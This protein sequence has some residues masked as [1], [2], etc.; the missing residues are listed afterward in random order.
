MKLL[1]TNEE[2]FGSEKTKNQSQS[3]EPQKEDL[4]SFINSFLEK[5]QIAS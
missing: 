3:K 1:D 5:K 2:M 4:G